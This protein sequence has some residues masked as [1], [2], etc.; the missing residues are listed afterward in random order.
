MSSMLR[1][2]A[3][4]LAAVIAAVVIQDRLHRPAKDEH[5]AQQIEELQRAQ[6][7][8]RTLAMQTERARPAL[9]APTPAPAP[10]SARHERDDAA[11]ADKEEARHEDAEPARTSEELRAAI[12]D[13]FAADRDDPRW[14]LDAQRRAEEGLKRTLPGGSAALSVRCTGSMCRIETRHH[15]MEDYRHFVDQALMEPTTALWN[16]GTFSS[17]VD[18]SDSGEVT[19]VSYL[20]RDGQ[21]LPVVSHL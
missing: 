18:T 17:V 10:E 1:T 4:A 11:P 20:A 2:S 8:L 14:S 3:I 13:V 7:E 12:A 19:V 15:T 16:G 21:A 9:G 5:L 6:R